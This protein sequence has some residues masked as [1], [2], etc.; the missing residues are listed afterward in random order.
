MTVREKII[1]AAKKL[2]WSNSIKKVSIVDICK[3]AEVSKMS[4]YRQFKNKEELVIEI[5]VYVSEN[6]IEVYKEI[7]N[8]DR[9]FSERMQRLV[10]MKHD[11][12]QDL[13]QDFLEEVYLNGGIGAEK[14][15][16][17]SQISISLFMQ[18]LDRARA[19]GDL[20]NDLSNEFILHMMAHAQNMMND[21]ALRAMYPN[22]QD[23]ITE[24]T[25]FFVFGIIGE[26]NN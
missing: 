21:P 14:L 5:L 13:S 12:T 2:F 19:E 22:P 9:P 3:E 6:A 7:I 1:I 24:V 4:F 23:L 11:M 16:E 8:S 25:R 20:R 10:K 26:K 15:Q 18:D 17:M